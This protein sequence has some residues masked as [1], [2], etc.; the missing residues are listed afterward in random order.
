MAEH[1][2]PRSKANREKL[3]ALFAALRVQVSPYRPL[4][5]GET[6]LCNRGDVSVLVSTTQPPHWAAASD[7]RRDLVTVAVMG[8]TIIKFWRKGPEN[9]L[10]DELVAAMRPLEWRG[11]SSAD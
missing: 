4:A 1:V 5:G 7:E 2:V 10:R 3:P 8:M 9:A 11:R 6:W